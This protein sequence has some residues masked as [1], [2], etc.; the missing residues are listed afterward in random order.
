[1]ASDITQLKDRLTCYTADLR[2]PGDRGNSRGRDGDPPMSNYVTQ[3]EFKQA[4]GEI[5]SDLASAR[6]EISDI[7][8][9]IHK[10]IVETQRW[11]FATVIGLFV[12]FGGLFMAMSNALKPSAP[13][14]APSPI[15]IQVPG[16]LPA[17]SQPAAK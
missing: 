1:M 8:S 12:G 3:D 11:M 4:V 7:R 10:G 5:K 16:A 15:V 9:D 6:T 13:A 14:A 2:S 17:P